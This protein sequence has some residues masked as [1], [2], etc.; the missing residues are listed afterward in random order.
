MIMCSGQ[1]N[2]MSRMLGESNFAKLDPVMGAAQRFDGK[3]VAPKVAGWLG[4]VPRGYTA[5]DDKPAPAA[6]TA[7]PSIAERFRKGASG[8]LLTGQQAIPKNTLLGG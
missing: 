4:Q 1:F 7:K 3:H 2:P 5:P 6:T 8:S